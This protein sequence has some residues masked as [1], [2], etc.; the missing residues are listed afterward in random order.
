MNGCRSGALAGNGQVV[1]DVDLKL[2]LS[3]SAL[4]TCAGGG[5]SMHAGEVVGLCCLV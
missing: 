4:P 1:V 3:F 2:T 5:S